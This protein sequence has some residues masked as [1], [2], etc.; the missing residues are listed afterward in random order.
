MSHDF[1]AEI[2]RRMDDRPL[3][4]RRKIV[5]EAADYSDPT[6]DAKRLAVADMKE[7]RLREV[8]S[9]ILSTPGGREWLWGLLAGTHLFDERVA[10]SGSDFE[11]GLYIGQQSIGKDLMRR[12]C[13]VSPENWARMFIE[14]DQ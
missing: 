10:M 8:E 7:D 11:H 5:G 9:A 1:F 12:F 6:E 2:V 14:Q 4:R 13:R 3:P